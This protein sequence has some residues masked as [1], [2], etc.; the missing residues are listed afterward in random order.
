[1]DIQSVAKLAGVSTAT[2]SRVLNDSPHVK[3]ST[4]ER[5]KRLIAELNYVPNTSAR[6]LRIGRS[7]LLGLIV[8]DV[9]NPFFPEL[10]DHFER[11]AR[12]QGIDVIFSHT[13]YDSDRLAH[14]LQRMVE[15]NVDGVAVCT[16]EMNEEALAA[17]ARFSMPLVLMNQAGPRTPYTNIVVDHDAGAREAIDHLYELGHRR[18]GFISGPEEF[19]STRDRKKAFLAAMQ[20]REL[21][22]RPEWMAVG[23]L[24][25][26]GGQQAGARLLEGRVRPTAIFSSNDLM[27]IGVMHIAREKGLEVPHD[28]SVVG[29][30]NLPVCSMMTPPLS[31]VDIP[32]DRIAAEAVQALLRQSEEKNTEKQK[33]A[34][35]R[36]RFV[37][38]GSTAKPARARRS[39]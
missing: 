17:A 35:L 22:V 29:F 8:S 24:H 11:M 3:R 25:L 10:I 19:E 13:N 12:E 32:R 2:I 1:M 28:L 15:R 5:V 26:E 7:K 31:S 23:D 6:N 18:I 14:C 30:D 37:A 21:E 33:L 4:Y 16:S 27:A 38:R 36:T 34:K 39:S 20:R 9:N